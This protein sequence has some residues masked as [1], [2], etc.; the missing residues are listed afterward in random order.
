MTDCFVLH[1]TVAIDP[2]EHLYPNGECL[3]RRVPE[4][5][6]FA[7]DGFDPKVTFDP[8]PADA[9]THPG[10]VGFKCTH[11]PYEHPGTFEGMGTGGVWKVIACDDAALAFDHG[12]QV[13]RTGKC[14]F[15]SGN[16]V[17]CG[18]YQGA[19]A[20]LAAQGLPAAEGPNPVEW[21]PRSG[22]L[23]LVAV[24]ERILAH[25]QSSHLRPPPLSPARGRTRAI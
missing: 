24:H 6:E 13:F 5:G 23:D 18:N 9:T 19:R 21:M 1:T 8:W 20:Y 7:F 11:V 2:P 12:R 14:R 3:C 17:F 4:R 22:P 15:A 10:V 16:V 25:R